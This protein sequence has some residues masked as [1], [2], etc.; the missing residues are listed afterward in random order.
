MEAYDLPNTL[1]PVMKFLDDASNWYVRRSRRRF[2]KSGDDSDKNDA[3][4]TLHYVLTRLSMV[5]AP[6]VPFLA[7]ELFLKLTGGE[8]G[9]SVHLLDWP[10]VGPINEVEIAKMHLLRQVINAK[11]ADRANAGIKVRQPLQKLTFH[12]KH[13]FDGEYE[14]ILKEELNVREIVSEQGLQESI[15]PLS[16]GGAYL[17]PNADLDLEIT[18][19]LKREGLMRELIR[20]VQAARKAADLNVDDRIVL[21][22]TSEDDEVLQTLKEHAE[23]IVAETLA[24]SFNEA[25]PEQFTTETKVDGFVVTIALAKA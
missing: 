6:F 14:S 9:E 20:Q 15:N 25:K 7:E 2:W 10:E 22:I 24:K 4:Q 11:L 5:L 12:S 17:M 8:L 1:E 18:P 13:P 21:S 19:E 16:A 23:T 3:Y